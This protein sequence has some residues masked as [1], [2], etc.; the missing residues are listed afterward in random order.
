[1]GCS[2]VW[3]LQP[4]CIFIHGLSPNWKKDPL[5]YPHWGYAQTIDHVTRVGPLDPSN[6]PLLRPPPIQHH[7]PH[8][9]IIV[10]LDPPT[11][12]DRAYRSSTRTR[13]Y[14]I[15]KARNR[16]IRIPT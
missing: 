5:S 9:I 11:D 14:S 10:S 16:P 12:Y 13:Y 2:G 4:E 3:C 7:L 6:G 15:P 8:N 1:M